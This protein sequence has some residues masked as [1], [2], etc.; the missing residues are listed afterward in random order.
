MSTLAAN[1]GGGLTMTVVTHSSARSRVVMGVLFAASLLV[2]ACGQEYEPVF[3]TDASDSHI[4]ADHDHEL[5]SDVGSVD[6][7]NGDSDE[8]FEFAE[9]ATGSPVN[10]LIEE[11]SGLVRCESNIASDVPEFY[12]RYFRCT[13][14]WLDGGH[15]VVIQ[16]SNLPPHDSYYYGQESLF[17]EQFDFSRGDDYRPNP[18]AIKATSF[19]MRV[20]LDPRL[21]DIT[22]DDDTVN[23]T[24]GDDT[25]YPFGITGV[26]LDGVALFNPLAAPGDDIEDEKYTFDSNEGHPQ[27]DGIYHYH[28]V[29][30]GPL[31][32]LQG[33]GFTT[34]DIPGTAEIEL[35]GVMCDGTVVM[36]AGELNGTGVESELDAQ[37]GH[38]HDIA[39]AS[40]AVLLENRY[41]IH[42]AS[43]IG[44]EPRG[45]T[46]EAQYYS[47]CHH[48]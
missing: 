47:T 20:P 4:P 33:L 5:D 2:A 41:H 31:A 28:A 19:I 9:P 30:V 18:N 10:L 40:G 24:A 34:S 29:A 27:H 42:M 37:A 15:H 46:P 8:S 45:L 32:V 7:D 35:Y 36:G 26:G 44:A 17:F 39:D 11:P 21:A 6:D 16:G 14:I 3:A 25:D 22:I 38:V 48:H 43:S 13:D 12:A 23:L 1:D